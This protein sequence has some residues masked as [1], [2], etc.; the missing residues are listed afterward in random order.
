MTNHNRPYD[1]I[2]YPIITLSYTDM[3]VSYLPR[4]QHY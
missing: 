2:N 1:D 3:A 4:Y